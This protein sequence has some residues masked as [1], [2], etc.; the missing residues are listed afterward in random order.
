MC[1]FLRYR[2][3]CGCYS[4]AEL[5]NTC[6]YW[7]EFMRDWVATGRDILDSPDP[8]TP[9]T[10]KRRASVE[11]EYKDQQCEKCQ[12]KAIEERDARRLH[13]ERLSGEG[14]SETSRS[15]SKKEKKGK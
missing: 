10:G 11:D 3:K 6:D 15:S 2:F 9:W 4:N 14:R 7:H 13:R 5:N 12:K 8:C 1:V